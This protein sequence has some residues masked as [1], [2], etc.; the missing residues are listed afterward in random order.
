MKRSLFTLFLSCAAMGAFAQGEVQFRN[1]YSQSTPPVDARVYLYNLDVTPG[2]YAGLRAALIG[3][4][5]TGT[6]ANVPGSWSGAGPLAA[7]GSLALMYNPTITTLTWT[8]FRAAPN[9]G[10]VAVVNVPRT[11]LGV[12]WGGTARVQMVSWYG[13]FNTWVEAFSAWEAGTPGVGVGASNPLTLTLPSGPTDPNLAYLTGLQSFVV[14][15]IPEP[16]TFALAGL[17]AAA[18]L[19]FRRRN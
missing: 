19:H 15:I 2:D 11:V 8:G 5:T 3:G 10:Y 17:G 4:P 14:M 6:P 1:F 18:L 16:T 13:P 12:D 9:E 7:L